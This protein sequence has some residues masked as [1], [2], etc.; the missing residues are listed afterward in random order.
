MEK[1]TFSNF[2]LIQLLFFAFLLITGFSHSVFA[3][4]KPMIFPIP[5]SV[6]ITND[7]FILDESVTILVPENATEN[8]NSLVCLLTSE[9]TNQY[10]LAI[11]TEIR[12]DIPENKKVIVLGSIDNLLIS[13]Y[14][15]NEGLNF[16]AQNSVPE[17]Y[18]LNVSNNKIIVAGWDDSGAFY[19]IQSLRQLIRKRKGVK[20]T[21]VEIRDWPN[22]PV[23][24]VRLY[25][26]GPDN[27]PF[28][29]RFIKDFMALYKFNQVIIE[30][31][32]MRL[33]KHPE[34]NAGWIDFAK[35]LQ[36]SRLNRPVGK[37]GEGK[38]SSHFDAGD[39]QIIE[40]QDVREIIEYANKNHIEVVPEIP[41]LSHVY[42]LLARHPELA[43]Y[44]GDNWP[45]T[46]C[47][48][49]PA[50]YDLLF[51]VYDEYIDVIKPKMIH[52]GHD[53]WRIPMDVCPKCKGKDFTELY[54]KDVN[55]IYNYLKDKGIKT[56]MWGDHLLESVRNAGPRNAVSS[57]GVKYQKPGA[58]S[59]A[60]VR[61]LIPKDILVFNWFWGDEEKEQELQEFGFKQFFGNFKP[62]ISNW[63]ERIKKIDLT[64]GAPSSWAAT[65][66]FNFGKDLLFDFLGCAN[67]LWSNHTLKQAGLAEIA[68]ELIPDIRADLNADPIPSEDGDPVRF[69]DIS[70]QFN[71]KTA[72]PVLGINLNSMKSGKVSS[73]NKEFNLP[74]VH[75]RTGNFAVLVGSV[76]EGENPVSANVSGIPVNED[77]SSLL[78]LH[79]CALPAGNQKAYY[80]IPNFFDTSDLLGWYEIVYEDGFKIN[81]PIQYGVNILEWNSG[82]ENSFDKRE[83]ETGS[84]QNVYC[85]KADPIKCSSNEKE[86][87]ITFYA[88]E[89]VNPRFGKIIKEVNLYG[90]VN[91]QT[92]EPASNPKT[93]PMKSNAIILAALS[94]VKRRASGK[95]T[96]FNEQ[97]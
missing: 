89:W 76:G 55:K 35:D 8:D 97:E 5:Q 94:K 24:A 54:I 27:I 58:L 92:T 40:K 57:I 84:P 9:L 34:I 91:Y 13:K 39:G 42:Y 6:Q 22:L 21:G 75:N 51:D 93:N 68:K 87:Q 50:S 1:V 14:L 45:D 66:E 23:R 49:N 77:V 88:F 7:D 60:Q 86:N 19:G 95:V 70:S 65:N 85:Y 46:Y 32:C 69:I 38:T 15:D 78:F 17:G 33:D 62:N 43:E 29:K 83:G 48:S 82:N 79:A 53:E 63:D 67:L 90:T 73:E 3:I 47:P 16:S 26:P 2:Y 18:I 36:Y 11:K 10:G 80:N 96:P 71:L 41:S 4:E 30:F 28:F 74:D 64:G 52:I 37:R 61:D 20:V 25:V 12:S 72:S 56:A 44:P 31:N 81:V 59:A